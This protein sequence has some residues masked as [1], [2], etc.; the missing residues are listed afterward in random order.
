M[1][2]TIEDQYVLSTSFQ[3]ALQLYQEGADAL[4]SPIAVVRLCIAALALQCIFDAGK[5]PFQ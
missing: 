5:R 4:T 2:D 3:Q 1:V